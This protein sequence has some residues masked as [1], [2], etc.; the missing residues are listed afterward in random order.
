MEDHPRTCKWLGSPPFISHESRPFGRG[1]TT[2]SLGDEHDHHGYQPL[3]SPGMILQVL[4]MGKIWSTR[5]SWGNHL[6]INFG[7]VPS[8]N[9][10]FWLWEIQK[11]VWRTVWRTVGFALEVHSDINLPGKK[12]C[13]KGSLHFL[14]YGHS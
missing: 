9:I 12:Q 2:R 4:P 8:R 5:T 13:I 3:T 6:R 1:P 7:S 14:P 10:D 11:F